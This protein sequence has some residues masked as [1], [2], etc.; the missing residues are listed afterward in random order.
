VVGDV[1][2]TSAALSNSASIESEF[3]RVASTQINMAAVNA[4][5]STTVRN[6]RGAVT[7]TAAAIGNS[8]TVTGF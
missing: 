3:G 2:Q 7:A 4:D 5:M 1:S 6:V 8:L